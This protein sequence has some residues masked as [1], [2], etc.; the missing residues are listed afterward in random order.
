MKTKD[1]ELQR[2]LA[3]NERL[4]ADLTARDSRIAGLEADH[5][6]VTGELADSASLLEQFAADQRWVLEKGVPE[7]C[8]LLDCFLNFSDFC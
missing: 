1:E 4:K 7:V 8:F 2:A 3:E 6:R 5:A